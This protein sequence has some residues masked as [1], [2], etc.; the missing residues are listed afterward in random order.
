MRFGDGRTSDNVESQSG[1]GGFGGGG[2]GGGGDAARPG[3]QPLRHR[4]RGRAAGRH[5]LPRRQSARADAAAAAGG[6]P[7]G[8]ASSAAAPRV[9]SRRSGPPLRLPGAGLDRG[10]R[11][12]ELFRAQG[13]AYAPP[14]LVFYPGNGQSGCGAAQSA[15]GPF[16]CPADQRIYLDTSFFDELAQRYG[17]PGDF[18]QAY[19]IAH[20][21][22]HHVQTLTGI[23]ERV[24]RAQAGASEAQSNAHPGADGAAGRL[25]CRRLGVARAER[26]GARRPRGRDARRRGDRRRHAAARTQGV[27]VPESFTHGTSAQRQEALMRGYRGGTPAGLRGIYGGDCDGEAGIDLAFLTEARDSGFRRNENVATSHASACSSPCC[28]CRS[29]PACA[30][31][32]PAPPPFASDR[33]AVEVHGS[34]PDV[35]L[36]PGLS[37]SPAG[38]GRDDRGGAGLSLPCRPRRRLRR[39]P[40]GANAAGPVL[41]PV[42]EEIARYISEAH[43]DHPAIVGHSM[44]GSWAMMVAGRHP[45]LAGKVMVVDML[46]VP[47]RDVRRPGRDPRQ[48]PPDRRADPPGHRRLGRRGAPAPDRADHRQHGE[49][50]EPAARR[51]RPVAGQRSRRSP[52]RAFTTSSSPTCG[53][54]SPTSTC[55]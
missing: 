28:S 2:G 45:E 25:L 50:R 8:A 32:P 13:A 23:E 55:R 5:V 26:D 18:A 35:V 21:V 43:L 7:A 41:A 44:G 29:P 34:G 53:P 47:R 15:M 46:P 6:A 12:R 14:T 3:V 48:H 11:G 42:A 39:R 31:V 1:G 9:C 49:D 37:S 33:I 16:Y 24:R 4:R 22:G 10:S 17:A 30:T 27:V 52:R 20:E 40:A 19:V 36:I 54:T 38:L 51:R